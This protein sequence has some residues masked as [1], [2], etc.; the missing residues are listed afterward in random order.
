MDESVS[1]T[2]AILWGGVLPYE[3]TSLSFLPRVLDCV[4][5]DACH[6][7]Q[8]FNLESQKGIYTYIPIFLIV[9]YTFLIYFLVCFGVYIHIYR[10]PNFHIAKRSALHKTHGPAGHYH[11]ICATAGNHTS[12]KKLGSLTYAPTLP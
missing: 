12:G 11:A 9:I 8:F 7:L 3:A 6:W 5:R 10:V 1:Q 4:I 2:T